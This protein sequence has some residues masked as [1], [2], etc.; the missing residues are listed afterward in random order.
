[1]QWLAVKGPQML[2]SCKLQ[3]GYCP[4]LQQHINIVSPAVTKTKLSVFRRK[5]TANC[6]RHPQISMNFMAERKGGRMQVITWSL[7][8]T[9]AFD[10]FQV[11]H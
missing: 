5:L 1:M 9:L 4:M 6:L 8:I 10:S 2:H 7:Q 11:P 3:I